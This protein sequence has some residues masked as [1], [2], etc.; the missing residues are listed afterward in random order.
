MKNVNYFKY[1]FSDKQSSFTWISI[2][3]GLLI[4]SIIS[5]L[6]NFT[7]NGSNW[8]FYEV[9]NRFSTLIILIIIFIG[10]YTSSYFNYLKQIKCAESHLIENIEN[11]EV[12]VFQSSFTLKP[13]RQNY[14]AK[15]NVKPRLEKYQLITNPDYFILLGQL[16]EFGLFRIHLKPLAFGTNGDK[17]VKGFKNL[18][19]DRIENLNSD[20]IVFLKKN[21]KSINKLI[22]KNIKISS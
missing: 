16:R 1:L 9:L 8:D 7:T 6:M 11:I 13:I 15:I 14:D 4:M 2:F 17:I 22:M 18:Q 19:V 10:Y 3:C 21:Y 12:E 5:L 20:T